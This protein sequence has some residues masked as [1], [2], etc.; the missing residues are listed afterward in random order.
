MHNVCGTIQFSASDL[1][2]SL[3]CRH[4]TTLNAAVETVDRNKPGGRDTTL[5]LLRERSDAAVGFPRLTH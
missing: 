2:N 1:V 4:L 3:S 5:G